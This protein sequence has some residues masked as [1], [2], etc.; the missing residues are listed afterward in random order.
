[1]KKLLVFIILFLL[2][3]PMTVSAFQQSAEDGIM[4]IPLKGHQFYDSFDNPFEG[5]IDILI[6]KI[7][8][9]NEILNSE[10]NQVFKDLYDNTDSIEHLNNTDWISYLAYYKDASLMIIDHSVMYLFADT[11]KEQYYNIDRIKIVYFDDVGHTIF[12]TEE[13]EIIHPNAIQARFGEITLDIES[14]TVHNSYSLGLSFSYLPLVLFLL[15]VVVPILSI[16]A[17]VVLIKF[18]RKR[19]IHNS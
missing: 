3:S 16:I 10:I 6:Y 19:I 7:D 11:I 4:I 17:I 14:Q 8:Y 12:T 1:M 9:G 18:I 2:I 15:Y 5:H 13:I